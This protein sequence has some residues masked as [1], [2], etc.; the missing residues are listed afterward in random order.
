MDLAATQGKL[1]QLQN[2]VPPQQLGGALSQQLEE[3][4]YLYGNEG[5]L[6]EESEALDTFTEMHWIIDASHPDGGYQGRWI[7][8]TSL[9]RGG[10]LGSWSEEGRFLGCWIADTEDRG[11]CFAHLHPGDRMQLP[12]SWRRW[13]CGEDDEQ[14][15]EERLISGEWFSWFKDSNYEYNGGGYW[16][17]V[18]IL[19]RHDSEEEWA[20]FPGGSYGLQWIDDLSFMPENGYFRRWVP[21]SESGLEGDWETSFTSFES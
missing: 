5:T 1:I 15:H 2:K 11:G 17:R 13:V 12:P 14:G 20:K 10:Y 21:A 19:T 16:Y 3:P 8:N 9:P 4:R 18:V 7:P 6:S